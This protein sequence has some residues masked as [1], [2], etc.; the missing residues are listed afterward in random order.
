MGVSVAVMMPFGK[1]VEIG[2]GE[3]DKFGEEKL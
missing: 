1:K 3:D 2:L